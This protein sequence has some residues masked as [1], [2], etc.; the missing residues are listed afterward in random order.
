MEASNCCEHCVPEV[1]V[2]STVTHDSKNSAPLTNDCPSPKK[3]L[4]CFCGGAVVA[5]GVDGPDPAEF[6][7]TE[8]LPLSMLVWGGQFAQR[9]DSPFDFDSGG[10]FP[11]T[12]SGR[13][14]C[15]LAGCFLL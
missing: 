15:A 3:V 11:P 4:S 14:I 2:S 9:D 1:F 12:A 10:Q 8:F 7:L 6:Y 13:D 5:N